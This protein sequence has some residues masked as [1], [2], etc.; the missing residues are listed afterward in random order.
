[1]KIA[2]GFDIFY[3][4]QNGVITSS[5]NLAN[6]LILLGHEIVFFVPNEK[7]F[8]E[9]VIEN[10]IEIVHVKAFNSYIYKGLK[11]L[12]V[13]SSYL[14]KE[15]KKHNID[16]VHI[17]S[18]WLI[19]IALARC[20]RRHKVPVLY[21]HHTLINDPIYI[22]YFFRNMTLAEM[23]T[24]AIWKIVFKPVFKLTWEITAPS[25]NTCT[26]VKNHL[27]NK[28]IPVKFI[29]NGIDV[30]I[31]KKPK[32]QPISQ[33]II[34][35]GLGDKTFLFVGRLGYE[36]GLDTLIDGFNI[37]QKKYNDAKLIIIGQGPVEKQLKEKTALLE[38]DN[39]I[40]FAGYR[41]HKE[42]IQSELLNQI[43]SF[44]TASLTENQAMT[45][46][47]ALCSGVA[48]I[49]A[50]VPNMTN[51]ADEDS[52]LYF[53]PG[54]IEDLASKFELAFTDIDLIKKK[55]IA[56]KKS[57]ERFDGMI[58][59]KEFENEYNNLLEQKKNGFYIPRNR[60]K[61]L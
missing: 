32:T 60:F 43:N 12:P 26:E 23:S 58:V 31:Y 48:C 41:T 42:I 59:A 19:S 34:D 4:E 47:E 49:T 54:N 57:I 21:T 8:Q 17:T 13:Y 1:M 50:D 20:A 51:L 14:N 55:R 18:P 6:N 9:N 38:L 35:F 5:I 2:F 45:I 44:V 37:L 53:K 16:M 10:G 33:D 52:A 61:K 7:E 56:A 11:I 46:I 29:S 36:K 28:D 3:P 40:F 15:F 30:S 24:S 39:S 22:N 25:I 27:K